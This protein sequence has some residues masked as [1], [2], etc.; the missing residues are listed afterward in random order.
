MI[1]EG[2]SVCPYCGER[3]ET[4]PY[5]D[6][7]VEFGTKVCPWCAE[8]LDS[9]QSAFANADSGKE[10]EQHNSVFDGKVTKEY[11]VRQK[12]VSISK[13]EPL[14]VLIVLILVLCVAGCVV[15]YWQNAGRDSVDASIWPT[16]KTATINMEELIDTHVKQGDSIIAVNSLDKKFYYITR[17]F[18]GDG[19]FDAIKKYD[20]KAETDSDI[21][22]CNDGYKIQS[23]DNVNGNL[24]FITSKV[25]ESIYGN[26][27][28]HMT[29]AYLYS[30]ALEGNIRILLDYYNAFI[31]LDKEQRAL[32]IKDYDYMEENG[33]TAYTKRLDLKTMKIE[34]LPNEQVKDVSPELTIKARIGKKDIVLVLPE[35][36]RK[37][38]CNGRTL[39]DAYYYYVSQGSNSKLWLKFDGDE[40][41][42]YN[43]SGE[44]IGLLVMYQDTMLDGSGGK[45]RRLIDD[46]E[47]PIFFL[48]NAGELGHRLSNLE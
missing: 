36:G 3:L 12:K 26:K 6:E 2:T 46:K 15:C 47:L 40:M 5:C 29:K 44:N 22:V 17:S 25:G 8:S 13:I 27:R 18:G 4:C 43:D 28:L 21:F 20:C 23:A 42:E 31:K 1:K 24:I 33:N 14:R 32:Y 11:V 48:S 9:C 35:E 41:L 38:V 39:Y 7:L 30:L 37:F 10:H 34:S 19:A 45:Y 16:F